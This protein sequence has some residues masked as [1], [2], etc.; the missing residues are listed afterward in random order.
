MHDHDQDTRPPSRSQKKREA[1]ELQ[2]L[3]ER[4]VALRPDV[5]RK[6][7]M[8]GDLVDEVLFLQD[9]DQA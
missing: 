8:P 1:T 9:A 4:L 7:E 6:A 5:L 2:Q 3:G